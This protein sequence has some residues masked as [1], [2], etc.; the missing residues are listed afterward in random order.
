M[1]STKPWTQGVPFF[2]LLQEYLTE[3][4]PYSQSS[5]SNNDNEKNDYYKK[6]SIYD[7][8]LGTLG[9]FFIRIATEFWIDVSNI[10]RK[11]HGQVLKIRKMIGNNPSSYI[12][13]AGLYS[14]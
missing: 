11:D 3:Y 13:T 5:N 2:V 9:E 1:L 7:S 6:G 4:I 12:P 8:K 10:I 14:I